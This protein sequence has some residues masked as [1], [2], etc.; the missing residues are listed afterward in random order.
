MGQG[1]ICLCVC[2]CVRRF[3]CTY[4]AASLGTICS[5]SFTSFSSTSMSEEF[6]SRSLSLISITSI[7]NNNY[8]AAKCLCTFSL[9]CF[10]P[11]TKIC[12]REIGFVDY[13]SF[14]SRFRILATNTEIFNNADVFCLLHMQKNNTI[15]ACYQ[16]Y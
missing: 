1:H 11:A 15:V 12:F 6:S 9:L 8:G 4:V 5:I 14:F 7:R 16:I 13:P 10:A 3:I 2:L